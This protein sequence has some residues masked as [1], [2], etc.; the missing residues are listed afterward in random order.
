[1]NKL[2]RNIEDLSFLD[3]IKLGK[4][5]NALALK[6]YDKKYDW[7]YACKNGDLYLVKFL[8][9]NRTEGCTKDAMDWASANGHLEVV[10][11]LNENI[12]LILFF[13]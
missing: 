1:M 2:Q 9:Y 4:K 12:Q 5:H 6:K 13:V 10:E 3:I 11:F 7:N 8:H